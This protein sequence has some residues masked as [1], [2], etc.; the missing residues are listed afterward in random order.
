MNSYNATS[1]YMPALG[2]L[3]AGLATVPYSTL[4]S[5][6]YGRLPKPFAS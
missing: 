1:N 2:M 5:V 3:V 4:L 6:S